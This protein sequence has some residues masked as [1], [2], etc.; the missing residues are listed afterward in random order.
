[1]SELMDEAV[2]RMP[3]DMAMESELS[4]KQFYDRAN[5]ALSELIELRAYKEAAEKQEP[6]AYI[7]IEAMGDDGYYREI[8]KTEPHCQ[9]IEHLSWSDDYTESFSGEGIEFT[10]SIGGSFRVEPLYAKP[11]PA[12][13]PAVAVPDG[14]N[15]VTN[16]NWNIPKL[17]QRVILF[18]N[19]VVQNESYTLDQVDGELGCGYYFWNRDDLD[20]CPEVKA[21][22]MWM[23]W[24]ESSAPSNS[25]QSAEVTIAGS[26]KKSVTAEQYRILVILARRALHIAYV[27]NDHNFP[28]AHMAARETAKSLNIYDLD[29]AND[30]IADLPIQHLQDGPRHAHAHDSEQGGDV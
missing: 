20:E 15:V 18:S 9:P 3:F 24:P 25:Q 22:D 6:R 29:G 30:F 8:Q 21:G 27:W 14:W 2:I 4:R 16:E 10:L 17:G 7:H 28:P 23:P 13:K 26:D 19:G 11:V 12:D 1:M 5:S